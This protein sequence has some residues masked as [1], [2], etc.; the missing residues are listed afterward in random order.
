M[1][2]SLRSPTYF[3][4]RYLSL[5]I[6]WFCSFHLETFLSKSSAYSLSGAVP[7]IVNNSFSLII[8]LLV[9][10]TAFGA[11]WGCYK[12]LFSLCN[13]MPSSFCLRFPTIFYISSIL[14][15]NIEVLVFLE[16]SR[17]VE[18]ATEVLRASPVPVPL[19]LTISSWT[20]LSNW[21]TSYAY[22]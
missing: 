15:E 17:N 6:W 18:F 14:A 13:W 7:E 9:F 2:L 5:P 1:D 10:F 3:L 16:A 22:W 20:Q 8:V 21:A 19:K 11:K 12:L 4:S